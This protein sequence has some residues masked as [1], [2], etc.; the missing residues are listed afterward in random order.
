[1]VDKRTFSDAVR[2]LDLKWNNNDTNDVF[3]C[4]AEAFNERDGVEPKEIDQAV[5][6]LVR[7]SI[8]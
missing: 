1:M 2:D 8:P 7:N 6:L 5:D 4:I 3:A